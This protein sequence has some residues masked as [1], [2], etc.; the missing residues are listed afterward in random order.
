MVLLFV[1]SDNNKC[2]PLCGKITDKDS[3]GMSCVKTAP[4]HKETKRMKKEVDKH[5]HLGQRK[6]RL[7]DSWFPVSITPPLMAFHILERENYFITEHSPFYNREP[8]VRTVIKGNIVVLTIFM[9]NL[10]T[11]AVMMVLRKSLKVRKKNQNIL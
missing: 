10:V 6:V 2:P 3:P 4:Q 8:H 11:K 9:L 7:L 1:T 5:F